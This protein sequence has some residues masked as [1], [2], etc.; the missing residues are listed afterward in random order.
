MLTGLKVHR[1]YPTLAEKLKISKAGAI[2]GSH[3]DGGRQSI[4]SHAK[5]NTQAPKTTTG[6]TDEGTDATLD[7]PTFVIHEIKLAG[8]V[9]TFHNG[10]GRFSV[11]K[12]FETDM[13]TSNFTLP[14]GQH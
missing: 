6:T 12:Y 13:Y 9:P 5:F 4:Q 14:F 2:S 11:L 10:S 3:M 1:K 8:D 7:V